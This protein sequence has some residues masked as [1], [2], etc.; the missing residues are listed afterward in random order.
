MTVEKDRSDTVD[1][2]V[3]SAIWIIRHH[4]IHWKNQEYGLNERIW[5]ERTSIL[6]NAIYLIVTDIS[7]ISL[8]FRTQRNEEHTIHSYPES[9]DR[10]CFLWAVSHA[11]HRCFYK[12]SSTEWF[13]VRHT[14]SHRSLFGFG[15]NREKEQKRKEEKKKRKK[16]RLKTRRI[17]KCE[18]EKMSEKKK[19][20]SRWLADFIQFIIVWLFASNSSIYGRR[21]ILK[22]GKEE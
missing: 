2:E 18:V 9:L 10:L 21:P 1:W 4:E 5:H 11:L 13:A 3:T 22:R 15:K 7:R 16:W 8:I 17:L 20:E 6:W 12:L 19:A 14:D